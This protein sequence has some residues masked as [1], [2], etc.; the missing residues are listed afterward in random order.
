MKKLRTLIAL[1]ICAAM[2]LGSAGMAAGGKE[3]S[4]NDIVVSVNGEELLN[5]SGIGINIGVAERDGGAGLHIG[6]NANG[7]SVAD[8]EAALQGNMLYMA[9]DG[10]SKVYG[11][12]LLNVV[13]TAMEETQFTITAEDEAALMALVME[14]SAILPSCLTLV[15][16]TDET[17]H[18]RLNV[19]EAQVDALLKALAG[20]LDNHPE[21]FADSYYDNF[22]EMIADMEVKLSLKGDVLMTDA[23]MSA[24]LY[25]VGTEIESGEA[26]GIAIQLGMATATEENTDQLDIYFSMGEGMSE[27]DTVQYFESA[28][29]LW[30]TDGNFDSFTGAFQTTDTEDGLYFALASGDYTEDGM[31]GLE[32]GLLDES[33]MLI[34]RGNMNS[35]V[36][37]LSVYEDVISL[38]YEMENGVGAYALE[39]TIEGDTFSVTANGKLSG[40]LGEWL[41]PAGTEAVDIM[42]LTEDDVNMLAMEGLSVAMGAMSAMAQANPL[43][44]SLLTEMMG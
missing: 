23:G 4:L 38:S 44:A 25:L 9:A 26:S 40:T 36:A 34:A 35:G 12:D 39:G 31:W 16:E 18:F 22:S 29:S 19:T 42:S 21:L 15:E 20:L 2:L 27:E 17:A 10:I 1:L 28:F 24:E 7:E 33:V 32:F 37:D 3:I 41:I 11:L 14:A 6:L 13:G 5:L 8:V 30:I 43:I